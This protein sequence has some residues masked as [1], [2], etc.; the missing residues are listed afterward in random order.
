LYGSLVNDLGVCLHKAMSLVKDNGV[1]I[2]A[3]DV[4]INIAST[5]VWT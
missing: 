5:C 1:L 3:G 4:Q 2:V